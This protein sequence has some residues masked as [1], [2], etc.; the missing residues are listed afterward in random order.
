MNNY[1][2]NPRYACEYYNLPSKFICDRYYPK[3]EQIRAKD[4]KYYYGYFATFILLMQNRYIA[5][6]VKKHWAI[7]IIIGGAIW[8]L[9]ID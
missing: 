3:I 4:F 9:G 7:I 6:L 8:E 5:N 1:E 2:I